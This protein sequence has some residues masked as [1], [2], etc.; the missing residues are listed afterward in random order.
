M[1]IGYQSFT[2]NTAY[3]IED[4]DESLINRLVAGV[5]IKDVGIDVELKTGDIFTIEK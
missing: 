3:K 2:K 5:V 1:I 4:S